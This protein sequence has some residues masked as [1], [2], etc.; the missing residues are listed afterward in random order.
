MKKIK[1]NISKKK[2]AS[3]KITNFM[4]KTGNKRSAFFLNS[5]C[6]D[7]GQCIAFGVESNKIMKLFNNFR[8]GSKFKL[9]DYIVS[10]KTLQS[11]AN[12]NVTEIKFS[13]HNYDVY[14]ILKTSLDETSDNLFYE[15]CIGLYLNEI[16]KQI[17]HFVNTYNILPKKEK[18]ST[19]IE[20]MKNS[21]DTPTNI[22]LLIQ[23]IHNPIFIQEL[24][25]KQQSID[26]LT[27][28]LQVYFT[29]STLSNEFTHYDLHG[30]NVLLYKPKDNHYIYYHYKY[31]GYEF[32]FRSQYLA[33]II[34]YGRSFNHETTKHVYKLLLK[35]CLDEDGEYIGDM[36]GYSWLE[37]G[38]IK[39]LIHFIYH[40]YHVI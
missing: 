40:L 35:K 5:V 30:R 12:G 4:K 16:N 14:T 7:S 18:Y 1:N 31:G 38:V 27:T 39:M 10:S 28:L 19:M 21:C 36:V 15:F 23:H 22:R 29:L 8:D 33:K 24:V 11:G 20:Y 25:E 26:L 9:R 6:K 2:D 13:R 3:K 34:D 17:P 32:S 37:P